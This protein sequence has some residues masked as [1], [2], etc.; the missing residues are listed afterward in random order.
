MTPAK[1]IS[2]VHAHP[3]SE[4]DRVPVD[5][6]KIGRT[7]MLVAFSFFLVGLILTFIGSGDP[8]VSYHYLVWTLYLIGFLIWLGAKLYVHRGLPKDR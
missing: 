4:R 2:Y 1:T 5:R 3:L 7:C 8:A 6:S